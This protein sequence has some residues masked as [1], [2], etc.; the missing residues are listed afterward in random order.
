MKKLFIIAM[1]A[2]PTAFGATI[3]WTNP[4]SF[5]DGSALVSADIAST[6]IEWSNSNPFGTVDGRQVV[7]GAATTAQV[8]NVPSSTTRCFRARTTVVTSKGGLS[9]EPSN[10]AC[11]TSPASAPRPPTI[12]EALLSFMRRLFRWLA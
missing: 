4:T 7:Q 10:V 8:P 6:T 1:L 11:L 3:T 2:S 9:S 12:V 5:D